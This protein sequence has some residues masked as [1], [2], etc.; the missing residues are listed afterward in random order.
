MLPLFPQYASATNG[1]VIDKVMEEA[2]KWQIIPNITFITNFVEHP[3]FLEGWAELGREMLAKEDYDVYLFS[4]HGLPERH[5][6]KGS[7]DGHCQLSD[8]YCANYTKKN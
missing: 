7:V 8:K 1:S 5:I 6:R 4:Y 2:R 3:A